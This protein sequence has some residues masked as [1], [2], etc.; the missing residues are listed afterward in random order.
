MIDPFE[1]VPLLNAQRVFVS[2]ITATGC[3]VYLPI[4]SP[5]VKIIDRKTDQLMG[6]ALVQF[7]YLKSKEDNKD[8]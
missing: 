2:V 3:R 6:W 5:D 8:D 1:H 4:L 7:A